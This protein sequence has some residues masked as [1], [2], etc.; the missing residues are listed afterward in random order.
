MRHIRKPRPPPPLTVP[1]LSVLD[2]SA[3]APTPAA[4]AE[5]TTAVTSLPVPATTP[6]PVPTEQPVTA[7]AEPAYPV[8]DDDDDATAGDDDTGIV[9]YEYVG[10]YA[11]KGGERVLTDKLDLPNM[12]TEVS[13]AVLY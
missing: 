4:T 9:M 11:D 8:E 2:G 12:T 10:C 1:L 6:A 3:P 13:P 5:P 7:T